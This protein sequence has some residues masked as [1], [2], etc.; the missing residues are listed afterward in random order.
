MSCFHRP[1]QV[2]KEFGSDE[3]DDE[4]GEEEVPD[5]PD[6]TVQAKPVVCVLRRP[7][8]VHY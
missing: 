6:D 7:S 1:S 5:L 2:S 4:D 8:P 3:G